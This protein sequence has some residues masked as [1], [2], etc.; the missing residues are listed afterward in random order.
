[1]ANRLDNIDCMIGMAEY[2]NNYF[3]LAI[4]DPP[5]GIGLAMKTYGSKNALPGDYKVKSWNDNIPR[6]IYF[7]ELTRCS[8]NQIIWGCN[9]YREF[10]RGA[11]RIVWDKGG[12]NNVFSQ[13][14]IAYQSFNKINYMFRY[15]WSGFIQENMKNK[16]ERIHPTQKPTALY[17]WLLTKYAKEGD[18]ILDTHVGSASSLIACEDMGFEYVG[19]ELDEDYFNA[20]QKRLAEHRKQ[21]KIDLPQPK[22]YEQTKLAL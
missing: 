22:I 11:G 9:F 20:A 7:N 2:E 1:M 6:E 21:I 3:D 8:K 10:I 15:Y 13:C 16:E 18:L 14:D 12:T 4:V 17:K 5:Y 19:F